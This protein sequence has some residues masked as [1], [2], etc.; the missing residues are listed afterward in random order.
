MRK[1]SRCGA[2]KIRGRPGLETRCSLGGGILNRVPV[3]SSSLK[4]VGY[5][6]NTMT[7]E[8]EFDNGNIYQYFDV[9]EAVHTELI[10]APSQGKFFTN[11]I[12]GS[13][14]YAKV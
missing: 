1:S 5:D 12:K 14:R 3:Q 9:P 13:Y 10:S 4:E 6:A 2:S 8:I 7:L 11:Q